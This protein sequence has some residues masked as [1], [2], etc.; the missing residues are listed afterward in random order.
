MKHAI[1][2]ILLAAP[3]TALAQ[4]FPADGAYLPLHCGSAVM[5]DAFGDDGAALLER[6]VVGD[7]GHAA[8]LRAG[9]ATDLFLRIRL[10]RTPLPSAYSWGMEFDTNG[11]RTNYEVL[12]LVDGAAGTVGLF[13]NTTTTLAND[14]ADPADT[15]AVRTYPIATDARSDASAGTSFGGD[16]DSVLSFAVPWADL[17]GVGI[18]R[19]TRVYVWVGSSNA[20][21]GL[22][23]DLAC[24]DGAGGAPTLSASSS[25]E[26]TGD[27]AM[28]PNNGGGGTGGLYGGEGCSTGRGASSLYLVLV[29]VPLLRRRRHER[30]R[31][32]H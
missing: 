6:D 23:G 12:I 17:Q 16:G 9:D 32:H 14:P 11:D 27:P 13:R 15:P 7:P 28:D 19:G 3:A 1:L 21:D 24:H 25:A 26:T 22:N 5:T 4:A 29:L 31:H 8:G 18:D 20:P 2:M 10:D 30:A